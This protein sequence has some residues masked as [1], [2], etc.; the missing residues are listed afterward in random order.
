MENC[1]W[2]ICL[3]IAFLMTGVVSRESRLLIY[4]KDVPDKPDIILLTE[5]NN[6]VTPAIC[7]IESSELISTYNYFQQH[8]TYYQIPPHTRTFTCR[9]PWCVSNRG[10]GR[11]RYGS[12]R[13]IQKQLSRFRS[14]CYDARK[15]SILHFYSVDGS[16][17]IKH[18]LRVLEKTPVR[19]ANTDIN[20]RLRDFAYDWITKNVYINGHKRINVAN[21]ENPELFKEI[22]SNRKEN[23]NLRV[24]P[25][26]GYLF[27]MDANRRSIKCGA[28]NWKMK[29]RILE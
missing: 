24:H 7:R 6:E 4:E 15:H 18:H 19:F 3:I 8:K 10:G 21:L 11:D 5:G 29:I 2:K 27:F 23:T 13:L 9:Q 14:L 17:I 16:G 26:K 12:N 20:F 1:F 25:N 28:R 22:I